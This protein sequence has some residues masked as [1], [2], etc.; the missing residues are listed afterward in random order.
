MFI[1]NYIIRKY[2]FCSISLYLTI[3]GRRASTII[4]LLLLLLLLL[5]YSILRTIVGGVED[6][7]DRVGIEKQKETLMQFLLFDTDLVIKVVVFYVYNKYNLPPKGKQNSCSG[8]KYYS[9]KKS[10]DLCRT[11]SLAVCN[12]DRVILKSVAR[13]TR[14]QTYTRACFRHFPEL[15]RRRLTSISR[16]IKSEL[17]I[18]C[19]DTLPYIIHNFGLLSFKCV[20]HYN[21]FILYFTFFNSPGEG[22]ARSFIDLTFV[23]LTLLEMFNYVLVIVDFNIYIYSSEVSWHILSFFF[24]WLLFYA[25]DT[26]RYTYWLNSIVCLNSGY[27][28]NKRKSNNLKRNR[29]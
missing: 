8:R 1:I 27:N 5:L 15:V 12:F 14:N 18:T 23:N 26:S 9:A 17:I 19:T 25:S 20:T 24:L 16:R 22:G 11:Y 4:S 21:I 29:I 7:T 3:T 13:L 28:N 10:F 6:E 2:A